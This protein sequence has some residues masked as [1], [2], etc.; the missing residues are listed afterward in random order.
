MAKTIGAIIQD[1]EAASI[2]LSE[3]SSD[4]AS[5]IIIDGS[6]FATQDMNE[7]LHDVKIQISSAARSIETNIAKIQE[8]CDALGLSLNTVVSGGSGSS[9]FAG[10]GGPNRN[11][12]YSMK[13]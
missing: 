7:V 4:L 8:C 5:M 2:K 12:S 9:S 3:M 10:M 1:L 11:V 13:Y 6:R